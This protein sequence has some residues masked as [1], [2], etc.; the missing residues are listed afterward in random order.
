MELH[1]Y[2]DFFDYID[3][4]WKTSVFDFFQWGDVI[5]FFTIFISELGIPIFFNLPNEALLLYG[6]SRFGS[7]IGFDELRFIFL[8]ILADILGSGLF[9]FIFRTWGN[10]ILEK[11]GH[12]IGLTHTRLDKY[13]QAFAR[14]GFWATLLGRVTP[15][16]RI[17]TSMVA[18][19]SLLK[20]NKFFSA[21]IPSSII[22]VGTFSIVGFMF[23]D[24]WK[25]AMDYFENHSLIF[26]LLIF[27]IIISM[28]IY[29]RLR[30]NYN[31]KKPS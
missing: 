17:Y 9:Y 27:L 25:N 18:G 12:W 3:I 31:S 8:A 14:S 26:T 15:Y 6:G 30:N 21:L 16:I 4:L 28:M 23:R 2:K 22:W 13:Y 11:Y 20:P 5:I 29:P 1:F 24:K 10:K 19:L 7:I